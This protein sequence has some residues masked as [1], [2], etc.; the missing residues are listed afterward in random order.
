MKLLEIA[1]TAVLNSCED[2]WTFF[3]LAFV[4]NKVRNRLG[5]HL[6]AIVKLYSQGYH[7]LESYSFC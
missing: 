5:G 6:A 3:N 4:K 2:E 1:I 7:T